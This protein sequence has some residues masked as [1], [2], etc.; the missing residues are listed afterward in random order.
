MVLKIKKAY[1]GSIVKNLSEF[2]NIHQGSKI[3]VCGCGVSLL[4]FK[5]HHSKFITIGVNDVPALFDPTY[6][7]VTDSPL[8]FGE[9]RRT[10]VNQSKSKYL[11]TCAS[12]W[13]RPNIIHF[14]LA[15]GGQINLADQSKLE[16]FV[17]SPYTA[18]GLAYRLG[19]KHIGLI[20]VD[21]T[22]G[23]FYNSEDGPHPVIKSNY[24]NRVNS[25]YQTFSTKLESLGVNLYNLSSTSLI[26]IK[27]ISIEEFEKL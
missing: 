11:F 24:L 21:F 9:K 15:K 5:E 13:R 26:D 17:N 23:H 2:I 1:L 18:I 8:R 20:G 14:G 22:N 16:H 25:A 6:S 10:L 19:A 12:G 4:E 27:K 7:L 3:V